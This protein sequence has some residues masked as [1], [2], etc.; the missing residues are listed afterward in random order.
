M[1]A[2]PG[3][4][5]MVEPGPCILCD[6]EVL[7]PPG[8]LAVVFGFTIIFLELLWMHVLKN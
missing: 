2:N 5:R 3:L 4:F 6:G 7:L 8:D 1:V